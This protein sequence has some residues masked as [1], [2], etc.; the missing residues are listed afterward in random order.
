MDMVQVN[1]KTILTDRTG[2]LDTGTTLIVAPASD[3]KAIHDEIPGSTSDG[4]GGY[5]IPCTSRVKVALSFGGVL[6]EI[7]PVDLTF[8]PTTKNLAGMCIS[9]I[10]SGKIGGDRQ[11]LIGDVFLKV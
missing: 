5:T 3:A 8:Q 11:W 4:K 6:F 1:G 10:S 7:N 2:I 9:G